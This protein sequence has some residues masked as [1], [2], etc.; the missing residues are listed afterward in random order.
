ML[1][2]LDLRRL[3]L[4]LASMFRLALWAL[5]LQRQECLHPQMQE[6]CLDP[7]EH[8]L[9]VLLC[10]MNRYLLLPCRVSRMVL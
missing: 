3:M 8:L 4:L 1:P 10:R 2:Q 9:R 6:C 7:M 5:H